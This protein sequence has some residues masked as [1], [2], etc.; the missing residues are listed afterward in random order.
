M[1]TTVLLACSYLAIII[2]KLIPYQEKAGDFLIILHDGIQPDL[3]AF[4][5]ICLFLVIAAL[6][7]AIVNFRK[8]IPGNLVIRRTDVNLKENL[9]VIAL[10]SAFVGI[11][12]T[13]GGKYLYALNF[14]LPYFL[15]VVGAFLI[16]ELIRKWFVHYQKPDFLSLSSTELIF[17]SSFRKKSRKLDNLKS[18]TYETKQNAIVLNFQDGL[19]T[20]KLH[21]TD[22]EMTDLL[23]LTNEIKH[24]KGDTLTID[25]N[26]RKRFAFIT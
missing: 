3:P 14:T 2:M 21:L 19:D 1:K 16:F 25:D 8:I 7:L 13:T 23:K 12:Q 26:F 11:V 20:I 5:A 4:F 17:K 22:Y 24:L 15:C 6:A 18:L 10:S 9:I